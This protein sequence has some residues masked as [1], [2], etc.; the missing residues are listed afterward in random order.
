MVASSEDKKFT[1]IPSGIKFSNNAAYVHITSNNT[2]RG[3]QFHNIPDTGNI[4]LFCDMSSDFMSRKMDFSKFSFIYAGAQKNVGPAGV[5]VVIMK[6]NLI[7]SVRDEDL[8]TMLTYKTHID[9]GSAFNTPP[10]FNIYIVALV[11]KWIKDAGGLEQVEQENGKKAKLLYDFLDNS[12]GF[13]IG[14]AEKDSRSKMNVT[15]T[16]TNRDLEPKAIEEAKA[17]GLIGIKG[18]RS[19]GGMRASIYNAVPYEGVQ[20]LVEFLDKFKKNNS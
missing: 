9:K 18:H 17:E 15:F 7:G 3:T 16:F 8:F 13:Y 10:V 5:C 2:I 14:A 11:M 19:V 1:Y 12:D 4:P 6:K 20:A